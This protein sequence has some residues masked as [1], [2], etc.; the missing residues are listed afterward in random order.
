MDRVRKHIVFRGNVQGVGFRYRMYYAA[1]SNGVSG[2]VENMYDGSVEA[3]LEGTELAIDMT[4]SQVANGR[5]V[6]ISDMQVK[7]V[8]I[9]NDHDFTV[10]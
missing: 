4:V 9:H 8:P 1:R 10:R 5:F 6:E 3:E 7:S 2:W